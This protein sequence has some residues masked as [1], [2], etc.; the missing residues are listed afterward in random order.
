MPGPQ[1]G[2]VQIRCVLEKSWVHNN[3]IVACTRCSNVEWG[4]HNK[5][6]DKKDVNKY[7]FWLWRYL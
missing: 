2:I 7:Y 6:I 5:Q 3:F 4:F 1:K